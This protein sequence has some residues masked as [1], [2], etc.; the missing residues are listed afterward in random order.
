[1]PGKGSMRVPVVP[2]KSGAYENALFRSG[3]EFESKPVYSTENILQER[4][5][6]RHSKGLPLALVYEAVKAERES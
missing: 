5:G 3:F 6:L 4:A 1:M 2:H